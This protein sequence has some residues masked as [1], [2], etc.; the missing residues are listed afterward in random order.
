M[1]QDL[2]S[3]SGGHS[4]DDQEPLS[5][6]ELVDELEDFVPYK[7]HGMGMGAP[8]DECGLKLRGR[9]REPLPTPRGVEGLAQPGP[10][11][12]TRTWA[13]SRP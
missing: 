7:M 4:S 10:R 8:T 11:S 1:H 13:T 2:D 3:D 12:P 5:Y 9:A 6:N